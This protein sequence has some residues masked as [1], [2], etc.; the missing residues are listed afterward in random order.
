MRLN[1]GFEIPQ[2]GVGTWTLRGRDGLCEYRPP[3]WSHDDDGR[4]EQVF[5]EDE[6]ACR[7]FAVLEYRPRHGSRRG[8]PRRGGHADY[9]SD[10]SEHGVHDEVHPSRSPAVRLSEDSGRVNRNALHQIN[11]D[12]QKLFYCSY[13]A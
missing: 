5:P 7:A 2:I 8:R 10:R 11:N 1:N 9:A 4:A 3:W 12:V 6:Y 13:A